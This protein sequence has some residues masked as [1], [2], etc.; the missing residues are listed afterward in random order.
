MDK[1]SASWI[2]AT[3]D[4]EH[5]KQLLKA[6]FN[7]SQGA[8]EW[9]ENMAELQET[10]GVKSEIWHFKFYFLN[11]KL[12]KWIVYVMI[13]NN[14]FNSNMVILYTPFMLKKNFRS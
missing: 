4:G 1:P 2:L 14:P 12:R 11:T 5:Q 6:F 10:E 9:Q 7:L 13:A 8:V 3:A